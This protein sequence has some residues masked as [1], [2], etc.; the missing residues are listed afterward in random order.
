MKAILK[1]LDGKYYGTKIEIHFDDGGDKSI[2]ELW[3]S[4]DFEPSI[5]EL[6]LYGYTQEQ[7]GKNELVENGYGGKTPIREMDLV[8]DS[9]FESKRTYERA[10]KLV[11]LINGV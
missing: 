11:S 4:G 1:P 2:I 9:H 5:R 3:D 6:E 7:W 8:C 10:S